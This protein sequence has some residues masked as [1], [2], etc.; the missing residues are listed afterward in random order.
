MANNK[1][2]WAEGNLIC[3]QMQGCA[4]YS[5][6]S[7]SLVNKQQESIHANVYEQIIKRGTSMVK[8]NSCSEFEHIF[9]T[10]FC[11]IEAALPLSL[12]HHNQK[13]TEPSLT[14]MLVRVLTHASPSGLQRISETCQQEVDIFIKSF[15]QCLIE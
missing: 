12:P 3:L 1:Q 4:L 5:Y 11:N 15:S 13:D 2:H 7:N 8:L 10:L 6:S 9:Q 14:Y